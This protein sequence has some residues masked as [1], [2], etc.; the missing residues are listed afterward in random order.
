MIEIATVTLFLVSIAAMIASVTA[1][2]RRIVS[3]IQTIKTLFAMVAFK[4][5]NLITLQ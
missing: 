1:V 2:A 3:L 4:K 5:S